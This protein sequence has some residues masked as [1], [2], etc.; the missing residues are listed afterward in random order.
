MRITVVGSGYVG[1]VAGACLADLGHEVVLVDNDER[2]VA[3]LNAGEVLIHERFL[4]E[5]LS[6]HRSLR[7]KFSGDLQEA[8]RLS[9]A[10]FVA[11]GTPPTER[12][13]ADLSYI[14][15]VATE[16]ASAVKDYKVII[17]KSTVPVYTSEWI[18]KI[19]LRNGADPTAFDVVSNPEFLRE[20]TAVTDFLY[21]D[22]IVIGCDT[23]RAADV[24]RTIYAPLV[25]GSYSR[26][27]DAI[28]RPDGT[29]T[30]ARLI[31]TSTKSAELIKH[32]SNAFLAMKISFIN[33]VACVCESVGANV[34]EVCEGVGADSRIGSRFLNPGIGY[35]G[36]CFPKDVLAFRAVARE[37]GYD[38]RLL[39]EVTRINDEQQQRFIRKVR[40]ALWTLRGMGAIRRGGAT[41]STPQS[42]RRW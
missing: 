26:S 32:A 30:A 7:L 12:G 37:C 41:I 14:E 22:R 19:I 16:I 40:E 29:S 25:N 39:G 17:E 11:V 6:R 23:G 42:T 31:R 13:D 27:R 28:P 21:P 35:G 9:T 10:I 5:L 1:L 18:R 4:P 38:F 24:L 2:K 15:T 3:A 34:N 20:G 36:S 8:V 33:A